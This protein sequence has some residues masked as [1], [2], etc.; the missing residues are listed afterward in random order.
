MC[1]DQVNGGRV[2]PRISRLLHKPDFIAYFKFVE[3]DPDYR[4]FME[5]YV[6][7]I[8]RF[9]DAIILARIKLCDVSMGW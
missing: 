1:P 8:G 2:W 7:P 3:I 9:D 6:F 5:V 4:I